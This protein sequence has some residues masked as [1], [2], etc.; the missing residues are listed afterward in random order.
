MHQILHPL[1]NERVVMIYGAVDEIVNTASTFDFE[2]NGRHFVFCYYCKYKN[3]RPL[4]KC[5]AKYAD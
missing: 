1:T 2:G 5:F 4:T 3:Q